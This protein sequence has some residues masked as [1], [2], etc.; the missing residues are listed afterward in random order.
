MKKNYIKN[1]ILH[2][3]EVTELDFPFE[4]E[5][6]SNF[7]EYYL[8]IYADR[9]ISDEELCEIVGKLEIK[10]IY[11]D[12]KLDCFDVLDDNL[13]LSPYSSRVTPSDLKGEC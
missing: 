11:L 1:D 5:P 12:E 10:N 3:P 2:I 8:D 6:D 13:E 9:E 4:E 7:L